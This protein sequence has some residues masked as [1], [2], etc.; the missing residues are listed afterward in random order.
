MLLPV[1]CAEFD[2]E[3][4]ISDEISQNGKGI[5]LGISWAKKINKNTPDML[6]ENL[7]FESDQYSKD[8]GTHGVAIFRTDRIFNWL[9]K[10]E[11]LVWDAEVKEDGLYE[12]EVVHALGLKAWGKTI[13]KAELALS[14]CGDTHNVG[15]EKCRYTISRTGQDNTMIVRDAGVFKLTAGKQRF[16]LE[17]LADDNDIPLVGVKFNKIG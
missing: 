3:P 11:Q 7:V 14:A 16:V 4:V 12:A 2:G 8:Y 10:A 1:Y 17:N 6:P 5:S 9:D 13:S 15:E